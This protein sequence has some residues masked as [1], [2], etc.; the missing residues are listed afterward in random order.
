MR[1]DNSVNCFTQITLVMTG[2]LR[3]LRPKNLLLARQDQILVDR[4]KTKQLT[5]SQRR[6]NHIFQRI[7]S[8]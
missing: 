6:K 8:G 3:P 1:R 5:L 4:Q 7:Q 2:R